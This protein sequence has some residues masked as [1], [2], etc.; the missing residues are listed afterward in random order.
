MNKRYLLDVLLCRYGQLRSRHPAIF[1][2]PLG[3]FFFITGKCNLNCRFCWQRKD[4]KQKLEWNNAF[5]NELSAEEWVS[6]VKKLPIPSFFGLTGGE[7]TLSKAFGPMIEEATRRNIPVSILSNG[8]ALHDDHVRLLSQTSVRNVS[9]SLDGFANIHDHVRS[10]TGLFD[11][12][13]HSIQKLNQERFKRKVPSLTIKTV[14]LN[15]NVDQL[16]AFRKF[17]ANELRA[18]NLNIGFVKIGDH[19]QFSMKYCHDL[20]DILLKNHSELY[21]YRDKKRIVQVLTDLIKDNHRSHCKVNIYPQMI[22][23]VQLENF[24]NNNGKNVYNPCY[25]PWVAVEILPNGEVI[26]CLSISLGNIKDY[27]YNVLTLLEDTPYHVFLNKIKLMGQ[28]I[29][30]ACNI[31]CFL[32]VKNR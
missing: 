15:E 6:I 24:L 4:E 21:E 5:K 9:F 8:K 32:N 13:V 30:D 29:P 10:S 27:N 7:P 12:V 23:R 25:Y 18:D 14:L 31:C 11:C 22:N 28:H 19:A 2:R 1:R 26:P 16:I 17:C 3:F 20:S